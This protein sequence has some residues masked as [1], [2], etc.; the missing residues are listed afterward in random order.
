[1]VLLLHIEEEYNDEKRIE[2]YTMIM[3]IEEEYNGQYT[4]I[5]HANNNIN[6]NNRC[7]VMV[8]NNKNFTHEH[9][10]QS[11]LKAPPSM[12]SAACTQHLTKTLET[13]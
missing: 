10:C 7:C 3:H 8:S 12:D 5:V 2:Q 9:H 4:M 11:I 13:I 6:N 1:M